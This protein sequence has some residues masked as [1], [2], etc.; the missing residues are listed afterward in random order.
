[1]VADIK[2]ARRFLA[3]RSDVSGRIGMLGASLGANLVAMAAGDDPSVVS[4]ALLSPSLEYRGLRIEPAM[5]KIGSRP[6]L[7]VVSDDDAYATRTAR[8][9]EKGTKG[10]EV[11]H[12]PAAGH[13]SVMLDRDPALAGAL[14]DWFH[15]TLL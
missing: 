13:G 1:M 7:M 5:R 2:A 11:M 10:R 15:R 6:V 9:L 12:L 14:V 8:D 3:T 4:V